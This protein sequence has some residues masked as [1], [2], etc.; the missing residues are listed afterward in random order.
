VIQKNP[1]QFKMVGP[2]YYYEWCGLAV[3][4]GDQIWLN[5]INTWLWDLM[6]RGDLEKIYKKSG[7]PY[8]PVTPAYV[9]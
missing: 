1:G 2:P 9:K 4:K 6:V 5:W 3:R 7:F 8:W